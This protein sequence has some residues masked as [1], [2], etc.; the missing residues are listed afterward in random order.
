MAKVPTN[1][2]SIACFQKMRLH[3]YLTTSAARR[4]SVPSVLLGANLVAAPRLWHLAL[5]LSKVPTL[6]RCAPSY[7]SWPFASVSPH[8]FR[9]SMAGS[10]H[11]PAVAEMSVCPRYHMSC[12]SC[13]GLL[14]GSGRLGGNVG[15]AFGRF[16]DLWTRCPGFC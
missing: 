7:H 14:V 13:C 3:D 6:N 16:S 4:Y 12:P 1:Q 10:V 9:T 11:I 8:S 5:S 2:P 15:A